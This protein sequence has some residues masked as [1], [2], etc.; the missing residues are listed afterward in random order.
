MI[1]AIIDAATAVGG[2]GESSPL[3]PTSQV[4]ELLRVMQFAIA[5]GVWYLINQ[6]RKTHRHNDEAHGEVQADINSLRLEVEKLAIAVKPLLE[7]RSTQ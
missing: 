7:Q 6:V 3:S 2:G 4:S 1:H 5:G